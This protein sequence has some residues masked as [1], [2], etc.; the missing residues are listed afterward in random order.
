MIFSSS[1]LFGRTKYG[2]NV[3]EKL[4]DA[5][6]KKYYKKQ[7]IKKFKETLRIII[8][9]LICMQKQSERKNSRP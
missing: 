3:T 8:K 1:F 6:I 4:A 7:K 5:E 9:K 2:K